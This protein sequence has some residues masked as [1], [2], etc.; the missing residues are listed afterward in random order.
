MTLDS[1]ASQCRGGWSNGV[2]EVSAMW[3]SIAKFPAHGSVNWNF[4][5]PGLCPS[6]TDHSRQFVFSGVTR[7]H[8]RKVINL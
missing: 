8:V 6:L 2:F 5:A 7:G 1:D 4:G 3:L